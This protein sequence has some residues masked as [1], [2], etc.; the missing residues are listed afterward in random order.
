MSNNGNGQDTTRAARVRQA[1]EPRTL[2]YAHL[3]GWGMA[4][5]ERIMT[6]DEFEALVQVGDDWIYPRTGIRTRRIAARGETATSLAIRAAQQALDVAHLSPDEIDLI[7]VATSTPEYIFPSTAS[8]VQ[9]ALG[10]VNAGA[11]DVA[12]ACAG[13]IYAFDL[14]CCKIRSGSVRA[15][16]VIGAETFSRVLDWSDRKTCVLF[17][18]GAGAVVLTGSDTPGGVLGSVLRSEGSGWDKLTLP[19]VG[20]LETYLADGQHT[21]HRVYMDGRAVKEFATR[22]LAEGVTQAAAGIG[23]TP[24]DL[25]LIIPHQAN[26]RIL[27]AAAEALGLPSE[28]FYSNLERYGNTSAASIPI[29]LAEA[30]TRDQ[31]KPGDLLGLVGFGG[32]LTWGATVLEWSGAP[33]ATPAAMGALDAVPVP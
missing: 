16:L 2:R 4:V 17:G 28:K 15:A 29:A 3:T 20:S 13:F 8:L 25:D 31:L 9:A 1:L 6:N 5:P 18:D 32:G 26:Q 14:A 24:A 22:V 19:T 10:A 23:L 27:D 11:N 7:M 12:A 33:V 30:V 21:M